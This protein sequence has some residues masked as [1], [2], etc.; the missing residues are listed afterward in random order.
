ME[1]WPHGAAIASGEPGSRRRNLSA[2]AYD[3]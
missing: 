2:T 3:A 1:S